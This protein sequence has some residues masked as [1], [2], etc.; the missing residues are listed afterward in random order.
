MKPKNTKFLHLLALILV[1]A[2]I[3]VPRILELDKFVTTD[4]QLWLTRSANFYFA[5]GQRN[6][7]NTY[8]RQ[9]PGVTTMWAG[10]AGFLWRYPQYRGSGLS[11]I[12]YYILDD[13]LE[14]VGS[15]PLDVLEGGRIF[16]VLGN[17][18]TLLIAYLYA[19]RLIGDLPALMGFL[20]IAFDPFHLAHSRVLHLDGS[21]TNLMLAA[22]LAFLSYLRGRRLLDL[23]AAG[24]FSGLSWLTKSPGLFLLPIFG[25][26][27]LYELYRA[28]A[29]RHGEAWY[30]IIWRYAWPP[31][32]LGLTGLMVFVALWPAM[33]VRPLAMVRKVFSMAE[34]YAET[35]HGTPVFFNGVIYPN[36]KIGAEE[37]YFYPL[38]ILRRSTP[39]IIGGLL[40]LLIVLLLR[41]GLLKS[42]ETPFTL[43]SLAIF[44][45]LYLLVMNMGAKKFD[46]YALPVYPALD[47]MAA[48]GWVAGV[49]WLSNKWSR[50]ALPLILGGAIAVQMAMVLPTF[51]YYL[52]YYNPM[53]GGPKKAPEVMLIG[54]GE[55]LDQAAEY[56]NAKPDS[57]NLIAASWYGTG[58][59]SYFFNGRTVNINAASRLTENKYVNAISADYMVIYIHQWQRNMPKRI[60]ER[61]AEMEPEKTIW[62]NGLEYVR[63][64]NLRDQG[65][66]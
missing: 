35:G 23:L 16:I 25:L 58:C 43:F 5:L 24:A 56:L 19:R 3:F 59:F 31:V 53:M 51:P 37:F 30:R 21:L 34:R 27:V 65:S 46:R 29:S 12:G 15:S 22:L 17:T 13:Y 45:L 38:T 57:Q 42:A 2:A 63:I 28:L 54:W 50:Y 20:L 39:I 8:Q 36:G 32:A 66:S 26:L 44:I 48:V 4:E 52:S 7:A 41:R 11:Q 40:L 10:T 60:L 62:I 9:H 64:Y 49:R 47:L 33:W 55:G 61:V 6:F 1:A 14:E 18:F